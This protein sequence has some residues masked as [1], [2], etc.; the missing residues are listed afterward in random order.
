MVLLPPTPTVVRGE[1]FQQTGSAKAVETSQV[2]NDI[3]SEAT[4]TAGRLRWGKAGPNR[5]RPLG[6]HHRCFGFFLIISDF[7]STVGAGLIWKRRLCAP[8]GYCR[9]G[10]VLPLRRRP[11]V[12]VVSGRISFRTWDVSTA[13]GDR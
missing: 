13:F 2:L 12:P 5:H 8:R 9:L 6:A 10:S 1:E 3:D 7:S 11:A 4:G